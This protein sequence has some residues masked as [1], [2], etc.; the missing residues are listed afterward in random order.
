MTGIA[1][2][3]TSALGGQDAERLV[4]RGAVEAAPPTTGLATARR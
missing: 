1:A 3:G 2:P 4:D